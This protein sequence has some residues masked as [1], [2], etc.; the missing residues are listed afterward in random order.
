M[1]KIRVGIGILLL[2]LLVNTCSASGFSLLVNPVDTKFVNPGDSIS[3]EATVSDDMLISDPD[4]EFYS[5]LS[6]EDVIFSIKE[7]DKQSGWTYTF[8]PS[9]VTLSSPTESKSSIL[10]MKVSDDATPGIYYHTVETKLQNMLDPTGIGI[11]QVYVINTDVTNV[12]EFPTVAMPM[13]A[14]LGLVT[15]FGRRKSGL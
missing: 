6:S 3:Y 8:D 5:L 11:A 13:L 4:D 1:L 14:I 9:T 10:T 2:L 15:I 12:P 7:T